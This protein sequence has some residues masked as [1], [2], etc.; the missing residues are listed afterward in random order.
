M[1]YN[2]DG[3]GERWTVSCL[4]LFGEHK[5]I[6]IARSCGDVRPL[7]LITPSTSALISLDEAAQLGRDLLEAVARKGGT[8]ASPAGPRHR[9][10][11]GGGR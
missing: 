5:R 1:P 9:S 4:D 2:D 10:S 8:R 3:Y 11:D 7:V 6:I